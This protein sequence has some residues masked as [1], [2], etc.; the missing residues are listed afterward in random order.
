V[1]HTWCAACHWTGNIVPTTR[2]LGFEPQ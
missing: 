2:M 1:F